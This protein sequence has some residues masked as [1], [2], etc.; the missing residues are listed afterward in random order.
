MTYSDGFNVRAT[1]V[2]FNDVA[3]AIDG[4]ITRTYAGVTTGTGGAYLASP[5]PAWLEY[6]TSAFIIFV[7]HV[8]NTASPTLNIS[9]LGAKDLK[10]GG[11]AV[12]AG[13]IQ[14]GIPTIV[15]YTGVH[16]EVLLQ[17]LTIPIG[18]LNSFAGATAPTGWLLCDGTAVSRTTYAAL[19]SVIGDTYGSGDGSTTFNVPDLRR[20]TPIGTGSSDVLGADDGVAYASRSTNQSHSVPAHY[21]AMG[22]GADLNITSSG[23]GTTGNQSADHTHSGTTGNESA[24]HTHS[25]TTDPT[26]TNQF[27]ARANSTAGN[28]TKLM[29][30][31]ATGS[32]NNT[33]DTYF[34]HVHSFTTGTQSANHTHSFTTGGVSQNHT[35]TTPNHT[36]GSG[37]FAGRIGLVTGGVDGNAAMTSG[38]GQYLYVNYIIKH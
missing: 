13:V 3:D 18:Q 6:T 30:A 35:H 33:V 10:I 5:S 29:R 14:A 36:H 19:Y 23:S 21:H 16:F 31:S 1:S 9:S 12:G 20:R 37:N 25:G 17:N 26:S 32:D 15:A 27:P 11:V 34:S 38:T 8:S 22:T 4:V 24:A 2:K 28:A 7:P